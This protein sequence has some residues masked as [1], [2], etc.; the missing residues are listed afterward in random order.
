MPFPKTP[1]PTSSNTPTPSLTASQTPTQ[2]PTQSVCP[3]LTPTATPTISLTPSI[4]ATNTPTNTTTPSNTPTLTI[5][6]TST[7]TPTP[8][9]TQCLCFSSIT[10]NVS[11][12]GNFTIDSCGGNP[13]IESVNIGN[14]QTIDFGECILKN[15]QG[16]TAEYTIV[17]FNDCCVGPTPTPTKTPTNT[18]T[19]SPTSEPDCLCYL[20]LN[21]TGGLLQYTYTPCGTG[22][23]ITLTL[24]G[25]ANTR[26]C[27]EVVPTGDPGMTIQPC[28]SI[29]AC[30]DDSDCVGCT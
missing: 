30:T 10:I 19:P 4:T 17:S 24:A 9:P 21:E 26:V 12:A 2:T 25:G 3:G 23:P 11:V 13:L 28:V 7:T 18:P 5:T 15:T 14:N 1:T 29:T 22:T 20:I 16:G 8:T 27:S 6:N